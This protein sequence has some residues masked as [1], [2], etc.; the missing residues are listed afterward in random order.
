MANNWYKNLCN[1]RNQFWLSLRSNNTAN[2]YEE[3]RNRTPIVL[4]QK[5][6]IYSINGEPDDQTRRRERQVLDNFQTEW[7][8]LNMRADS[9]EERY[10]RIDEE[11]SSLFSEKASER[12]KEKLLEMWKNE[13]KQQEEISVKRWETKNKIWLEKYATDF[14]AKHTEK[15]PF[16]KQDTSIPDNL[17]QPRRNR[18]VPLNNNRRLSQNLRRRQVYRDNEEQMPT[19][20]EVTQTAQTWHNCSQGRN[21]QRTDTDTTYIGQRFNNRRP[22]KANEEQQRSTQLQYNSSYRNNQTIRQRNYRRNINQNYFLDND[23]TITNHP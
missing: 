15:N 3:W 5:L 11:M 2:V 16:I 19:Y 22:A 8:L 6:Q 21:H 9:H 1:R 7:D 20:A 12:V 17:E 10:R 23:E 18:R 13:T 14:T 4:P